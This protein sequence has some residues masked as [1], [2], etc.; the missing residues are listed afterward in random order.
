MFCFRCLSFAVHTHSSKLGVTPPASDSA[1]APSFCSSHE[2]R[3]CRTSVPGWHRRKLELEHM[4]CSFP[5]HRPPTPPLQS[6]PTCHSLSPQGH[7]KKLPLISSP[8]D[9][10][11]GEGLCCYQSMF[12]ERRAEAGGWL[13]ALIRFLWHTSPMSRC[14]AQRGYTGSCLERAWAVAGS[15]EWG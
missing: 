14:A 3:Q 4:P 15:R 12:G 2:S 1:T 13:S 8:L 11:L 9:S 10:V 6:P 7:Q 5:C